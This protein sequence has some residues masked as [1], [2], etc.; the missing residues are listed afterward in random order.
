MK[1]VE[2]NDS[3]RGT[4]NNVWLGLLLLMIGLGW[5][6]QSLGA[7]FPYW[8]FTWKTFLIVLG[9][10]IGVQSQFKGSGWLILILAGGAFMLEDVY[11]DMALRHYLWPVFIIILGMWL[12]IKPRGRRYTAERGNESDFSSPGVASSTFSHSAYSEDD[13]IDT[14][15]V[16]GGIKKVILSKNFKGGDVVSIFGGSEIDL[17][18]AD[19]NGRVVM[20]VTVVLGGTKL[21]LPSNW[22]VKS[23]LVSVLGGIEDKRMVLASNADHDKVVVL[24]GVCILGGLE[25]HS[26]TK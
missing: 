26:Y 11:P 3:K 9:I 19:I 24:K 10:G 4:N 25:I 12:M 13:F 1:L 16:L 6:L 17:S 8:L 14:T 15:S 7:V 18:Q 21:I 23:E 5:L 2:N 22:V 20:E